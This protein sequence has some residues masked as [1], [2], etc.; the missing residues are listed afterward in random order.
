V[1]K[2]AFVCAFLFATVVALMGDTKPF[3]PPAAT[4]PKT[5]AA[6]ETHEDEKVSI[7]I[8]PYD[9]PDKAKIF[10][11][12]YKEKGFLPIRVIIANDSDNYL[13][14]NDLKVEYITVKR[15]KIEPATNQDLFRRIMKTANR[16]GAGGPKVRLP[17]PV[18]SKQKTAINKDDAA[19]I[20]AAQ[21]T[22]APVDPHSLRSGFLFFD[23]SGIDTPMAGAHVYFS[24]MK[25]GGK[26][27]FYFD[28][29]LEKYLTY[30]PGK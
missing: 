11:I 19:E 16:P 6:H 2:R 5:Y 17:I 21:F 20:D 28:I 8:D 9:M 30:Q 3:T 7:A 10:R 22:P 27:L 25:S 23:V 29:P 15:D 24:G 12:N 14:L 1:K 4:H 18:P 13:M 26:E